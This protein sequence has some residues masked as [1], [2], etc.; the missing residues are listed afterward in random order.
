MRISLENFDEWIDEHIECFIAELKENSQ[1]EGY[2]NSPAQGMDI[3]W[4][5]CARYIKEK[6]KEDFLL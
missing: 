1:M 3:G 4:I 5:E 2:H 6:V